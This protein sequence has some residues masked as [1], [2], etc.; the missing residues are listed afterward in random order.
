MSE[1]FDPDVAFERLLPRLGGEVRPVRPWAPPRWM[2]LFAGLF[3]PVSAAVLAQLFGWRSDHG[4][5]GGPWVWGVSAVELAV[6]LVL[7]ALALREAVPGRSLSVAD[8]ALGGLG[9]A[10]LHAAVIAGTFA[11]SPVYPV[12]GQEWQAGTFCFTFELLLGIPC[13]VFALWLS[14]RGLTTRPRRVGLMGGVGAGLAADSVW[15]LICPYSAPA[16]AFVSHTPGILGVVGIGLLLAFWWE[17][18][19]ARAWRSRA[20]S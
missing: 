16:H 5:L 11:R 9:A 15:R 17:S 18:A 14:R 10:V 13:V 1:R 4:I 12:A 2:V 6:A 19:R 7:L 20:S 3:A 8:L